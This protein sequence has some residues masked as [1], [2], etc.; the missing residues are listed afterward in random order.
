MKLGLIDISIICSYLVLTIIIGFILTKRAAKGLNSY[1]LAGKGLPY[2]ILGVSDAGG[3][4]DITGTMWLVY[5][6]FVY[7]LKSVWLPWLWPVF[8]QIFLNS[9]R[10]RGRVHELGLMAA[11]KLR[12]RRFF[13]DMGKAP[14]MFSKGKLPLLGE[15][16][17]GR[18][19][20]EGLFRR[21]ADEVLRPQL[22]RQVHLGKRRIAAQPRHQVV[23]PALG[24]HHPRRLLAVPPNPFVQ[25]LPVAA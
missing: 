13:E 6:V 1:F 24:L 5:I 2:W 16:V 3:M 18:R 9:V 25:I 10:K 21:A 8:N 19:E 12:T 4:F 14:M 23:L 11:F 7:G 15:R 17:G 22:R 20:R